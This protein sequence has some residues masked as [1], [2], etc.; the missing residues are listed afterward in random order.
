MWSFPG[1]RVERGEAPDETARRELAEETGLAVGPLAFLGEHLTGGE[2]ALRLAV[3]TAPHAGG[4]PVAGDDVD[5]AA[6]V[7][8]ER[9]GNLALT[10][11]ATA[12]IARAI[13]AAGEEEAAAKAEEIASPGAKLP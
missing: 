7:A 6:F 5:Q 12:F 11:G 4:E 3:F 2:K 9:T 1:G 10:A 13:L 8:Y